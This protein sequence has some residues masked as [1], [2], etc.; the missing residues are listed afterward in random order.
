M[1]YYLDAPSLG[2]ATAIYLDPLLT[3]CAPDGIY[4]DG[5]TVRSLMGCVLAPPQSCP[6]CGVPCDGDYSNVESKSGIFKITIDLG[7]SPTSIGAVI[8]SFN[9]EIYPKGIQAFYDGILY[10]ALSSP[11]Y[12]FLQGSLGF[13]TYIGDQDYD[14]VCGL[15]TTFHT[16]PNNIYDQV[17]STYVPDGTTQIVNIFPA[18]VQTTVN[19]PDT[20]VFVI[21][22]TSINPSA[23]TITI[24]AP[25]TSDFG[26]TVTCPTALPVFYGGQPSL[27]PGVACEFQDTISYYSAPV[28]GNGVLLGLFDWVFLDVNGEFHAPDGYYYAPTALSPP[29]EWF[30][31][32]N[33]I[34]VEFGQCTY[35]N[36]IIERCADGLQLVA[37]SSITG[38]NVGDFV[39]ISDPFYGRCAFQV[40]SYTAVTNT[41]TIDTEL[42]IENC[43]DVCVSYK[44]D[45]FTLD[46]YTVDYSDCLG[47]P[48][49]TTVDPST[50]IYVCARVGTVVVDGE[51]A[52]VVVSLESCTC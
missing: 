49:T 19:N 43:A 23:L 45:N 3:E 13:P 8:V 10:N 22:K 38:V 17:T 41:V 37:D 14:S 32:E 11:I 36:F 46:T 4:S 28:N 52:G 35:N 6:S 26:L 20:C 40:M 33:G 47:M 39:F 44:V 50:I 31:L 15:T 29:Y 30:R 25:C 21:P 5:T 2:S 51:P 16:L 27:T 7:N 9:P 18:Q 42:A 12:G 34:I 48:Q 24:F 1:T